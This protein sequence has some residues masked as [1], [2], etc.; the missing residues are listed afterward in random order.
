MKEVESKLKTRATAALKEAVA[1]ELAIP[2]PV[3]DEAEI[4]IVRA[5]LK[6]ER[7]TDEK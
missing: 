5:S 2:D 1:A 4:R 7:A 6:P 3:E